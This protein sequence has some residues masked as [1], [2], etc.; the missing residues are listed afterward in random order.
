MCGIAW[1]HWCLA[2]RHRAVP[3]DTWGCCCFCFASMTAQIAPQLPSIDPRPPAD[4]LQPLGWRWQTQAVFFR[5]L[6][7]TGLIIGAIL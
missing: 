5:L 4:I 7:G 3:K 6:L 2:N 1:D